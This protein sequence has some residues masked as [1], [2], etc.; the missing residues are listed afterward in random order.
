M[1]STKSKM[2]TAQDVAGVWAP[3]SAKRD[4]LGELKVALKEGQKT[5]DDAA[6]PEQ[7]LDLCLADGLH[8][9]VR[10]TDE[11][12]DSPILQAFEAWMEDRSKE[13][14]ADLHQVQW[15]T[16]LTAV[17]QKA[18]A[19]AAS[20]P[21][22]RCLRNVRDFY[23][24]NDAEADGINPSEISE[25]LDVITQAFEASVKRHRLGLIHAAANHLKES[26]DT[27]ITITDADVDRAAVKDT[28]LDAKATTLPLQK[29]NAVLRSFAGGSC[30]DSVTAI[31]E[32]LDRDDDG[33]LDQVE[34]D[35]VAYLA[36]GSIQNA[37]QSLFHDAVKAFPVRTPLPKIG[38]D[39]MVPGPSGWRARRRDQKA[40]KR[41]MRLFQLTKKRHFEDE[42]E[43]P[44]RLRCIYAWAEKA[45]Q[46]N[47]IDSVQVDAAFGG[48]KRYVEL[49]PKISLAEFREVQS[50]HFP[51]LDRIG[52]ELIRSFREDLLVEQ[53]KGRQNRELRRDCLLFLTVV[54]VIDFVIVSL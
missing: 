35:R 21:A 46:G 9:I 15:E 6:T 29:L 3:T 30:S 39:Q 13:L 4:K 5:L 7:K 42:V 20:V 12:N 54:G 40:E 27:L 34:M 16:Y 31:W 47:K 18:A 33:L 43:M 38:P 23:E 1:D 22:E 51:H 36:T 32:L 37:V 14:P 50:E 28:S 11:L 25:N 49:E 45:H 10:A 24:W 48:R 2:P 19:M 44:H 8:A 17:S 41:L 52:C 53:G 26:W